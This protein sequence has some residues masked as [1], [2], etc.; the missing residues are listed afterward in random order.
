[1]FESLSGNFNFLKTDNQLVL[2]IFSLCVI[3]TYEETLKN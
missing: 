3:V 1:M 2:N